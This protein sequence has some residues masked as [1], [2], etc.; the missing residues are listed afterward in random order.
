MH[1][2]KYLYLHQCIYIP[3]YLD[4]PVLPRPLNELQY[5][6]TTTLAFKFNDGVI[7]AVD[8]KVYIYMYIYI[9]IYICINIYTYEYN[10]IYNIDIYI[11]IH[12]Y[13]YIYTYIYIYIYT[14]VCRLLLVAM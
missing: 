9:F 11:Y 8:S 10:Y 5:H 12:I 13:I 14:C 4:G 2:Y 7:V 6:G 1:T 3:K